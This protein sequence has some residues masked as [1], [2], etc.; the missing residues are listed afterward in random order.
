ME[1]MEFIDAMHCITF[2]SI[3]RID[4]IDQID[5]IDKIDFIDWI[6]FTDRIDFIDFIDVSGLSCLSG[7]SGLSDHFYHL[8]TMI[9]L[10]G[11]IISQ[12]VNQSVSDKAES[13]RC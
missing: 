12:S 4:F 6:D 9:C 1:F 13:K 7:L 10:I 3:D 5:F 2:G 11:K 8:N